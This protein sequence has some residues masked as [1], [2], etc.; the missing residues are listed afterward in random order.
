VAAVIGLFSRCVVGWSMKAEINAVLVTYA[1]LMAIWRLGKPPALL[2]HSDRGNKY[3][4][5]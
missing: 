5:K 3:V 1:L 4:N 2:H